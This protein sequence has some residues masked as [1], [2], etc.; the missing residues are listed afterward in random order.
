MS[1]NLSL[2]LF[3]Y[4]HP[5][6]LIDKRYRPQEIIGVKDFLKMPT[7]VLRWESME[8]YFD[9]AQRRVT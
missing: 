1:T 7:L 6:Q 2:D 4:E 5:N 9:P 8:S 3:Y